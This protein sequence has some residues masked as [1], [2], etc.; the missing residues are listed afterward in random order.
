MASQNDHFASIDIGSHTIRLLIARS[1]ERQEVSPLRLE[2]HITRLAGNFQ[3]GQTLKPPGIRESLRVLEEYAA[4]LRRHAVSD[5]ACGATGVVRKAGNGEEFLAEVRQKTGIAAEILYETSEALLS[6]KGVLSVIP[7][8]EGYILS[9]DLGGSSTEF[10]LLDTRREKPLWHTSVFIGAATITERFFSEDPPP[11][12]AVSRAVEAIQDALAPVF[13]AIGSILPAPPIPFPLQVVG[14]AGTAT[15]LAAMNLKMTDY[16][17]SRINGLPLTENWLTA[18][19][20]H[21]VRSTLALRREIPGLEAGREDIIPAGALIVREI[22]RGLKQ[23]RLIVSDAGLLEGLLLDL[24]EKKY[25]R[26][27]ALVS[28]LTWRM[29]KG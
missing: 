12:E 1:H 4:I 15:T 2:R 6:A 11:L 23:T 8:T 18:T 20:E 17:P 9:F 26:P 27:Q 10:L 21:L 29:Q 7:G 13:Q 5:V 22:L 24:I 14:T 16:C 3:E 19:I 25:G 28:P